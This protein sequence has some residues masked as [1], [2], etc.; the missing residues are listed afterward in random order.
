MQN[1]FLPKKIR[2]AHLVI[3]N[4]V[5]M[6]QILMMTGLIQEQ[7]KKLNQNLR[8]NQI[9]IK[10]DRD[11]D[12]KRKEEEE[13]EKRKRNNNNNQTKKKSNKNSKRKRKTQKTWKFSK[14]CLNKKKWKTSRKK[15]RRKTIM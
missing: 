9:T 15:K 1:K 3:L 2:K 11:K 10:E 8:F 4:L 13:E 7:R 6:I 14:K 12:R 5:K